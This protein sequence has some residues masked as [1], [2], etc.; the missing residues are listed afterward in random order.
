MEL[1]DELMFDVDADLE[2]D[3]AVGLGLGTRRCNNHRPR[4]LL[5]LARAESYIGK[6][7]D[8]IKDTHL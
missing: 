7:D 5:R 3:D 2:A 8:R 1:A 4:F 6:V